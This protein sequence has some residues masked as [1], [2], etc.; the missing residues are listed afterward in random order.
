LYRQHWC[1]PPSTT[2]V[3]NFDEF[4]TT[5]NGRQRTIVLG[6]NKRCPSRKLGLPFHFEISLSYS[7][8]DQSSSI[9][10]TSTP[11][12]ANGH[13]S[14]GHHA[15]SSSSS[16]STISSNGNQGGVP[17]EKVVSKWILRCKWNE[18]GFNQP[19]PQPSP[20]RAAI[21]EYFFDKYKPFI[22]D[23]YC[24]YLSF[25]ILIPTFF[26]HL[27]PSFKSFGTNKCCFHQLL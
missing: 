16:L 18:G 22:T 13:Q 7:Y 11:S 12:N 6:R 14:N 21:K 4:K 3:P 1:A 10:S 5:K 15:S 20:M 2:R 8:H 23:F 19:V 24:K 26:S 9:I 17:S 27:F 25:S